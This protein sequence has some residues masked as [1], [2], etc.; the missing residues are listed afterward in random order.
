M[1]VAVHMLSTPNK[2]ERDLLM[3]FAKGINS[4]GDVADMIF[5][6][7]YFPDH[8]DYHVFWGSWKPR[9]DT[10]HMVKNEVV[11]FCKRENVK[12]I[13]IETPLFGRKKVETVMTDVYNRI[14]VNGFLADT[15]NFNN[16]NSPSDRWEKMR[17][18]LDIEVKPWRTDGGRITIALQLPG[19]ASL[20]G[21]NI[22]KW[23]YET[24][25]DAKEI[26][27]TLG[28][29]KR[30][31]IRTPQLQREFDQSYI[32]GIAQLGCEFEIGTK[33][34]LLESF[35]NCWVAFTYSSGY[36]VDAVIN[37]V[38]VI[39]CDPGSFVYNISSNS[40]D[41][42]L[43]PKMVTEEKRMQWLYDLSYAQ[44][45]QRDLKNGKVWQHL[46]GV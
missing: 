44:W 46:R 25:R 33:E 16:Q 4:Y 35:E 31:V 12:F 21:A 27:T 32:D 39:A 9:S 22:S 24:A 41:A 29:D 14:G 40:V 28:I 1:Q 17:K 6:S 37:G 7:S 34:N 18:D 30:I 38:P 45:H 10:H 20:R 23:A 3:D 11:R 13:C 5:D 8:A 43:D 15:G 19:D 2:E 42:L 26:L 36:G